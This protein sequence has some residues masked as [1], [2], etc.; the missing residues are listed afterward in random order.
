MCYL[1]FENIVSLLYH[2]TAVSQ[3]SQQATSTLIR[4]RRN[5]SL[6]M[7][8]VGMCVLLVAIPAFVRVLGQVWFGSVHIILAQITGENNRN[9]KYSNNNNYRCLPAAELYDEFLPV[10]RQV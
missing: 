10:R 7:W 3:G 9:N 5:L 8:T 2:S 4:E 6:I 1:F